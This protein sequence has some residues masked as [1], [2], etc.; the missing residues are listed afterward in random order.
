MFNIKDAA[1]QVVQV[2]I[3]CV[4]HQF[5]IDQYNWFYKSI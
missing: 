5:H 4:F 2:S 3:S 1:S